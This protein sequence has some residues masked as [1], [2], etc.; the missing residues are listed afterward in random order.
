MLRLDLIHPEIS[1]NKWFKLKYNLEK[2][3]AGGQDTILTLGGAFS[4]HI[5]ATAAACHLYGLRS[6][7]VVRGEPGSELNPTL[8]KAKSLGMQLHFV[9]REAYADKNS[10]AFAQQL[11]EQFGDHYLI[12]EGGNNA[13]G[14]EGCK[15]ILKPLDRY[16][17]VFCACGTATTFAGLVASVKEGQTV[18]G[19]S[20]LKGEEQLAQQAERLTGLAIAGN[21]GLMDLGTHCI[22]NAYCFSGYARFDQAL[23][24]FKT[25]FENKHAVPLDHI[26]TSKLF[27]AV[28]DLLKSGRIKAG[29]KVL[30]V[31]SGGLQ[32]NKGFEERYH[33]RLNR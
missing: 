4:N 15:E 3:I 6:I 29:S 9:S 24:D 17:H 23:V 33:L 31:H 12:P 27:Y 14:V 8:S 1:G 10:G 2:A 30:I 7:A 16:D 11:K 32:G 25:A 28:N 13:A 26:Y 18:T 19:I 5:A 20:V 22:S 21:E